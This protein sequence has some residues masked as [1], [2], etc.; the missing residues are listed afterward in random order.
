MLGMTLRVRPRGGFDSVA[1]HAVLT[2][3]RPGPRGINGEC[4]KIA[5]KHA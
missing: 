5:R 2:Y 3:T 1:Q 4:R